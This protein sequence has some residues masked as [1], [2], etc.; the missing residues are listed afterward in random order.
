MRR[1]IN[2]FACEQKIMTQPISKPVS[3]VGS[4]A[5]VLSPSYLT[6]LKR[7][8]DLVL[9]GGETCEVWELEAPQDHACLSDW[10]RRFRQCYC[11]DELLE[12]LVEGTGKS[13]SQYLLE[14]VLPDK[15]QPP[16]PGIRS[17]DFAELLIADFV[18]FMLKYWV[19]REKYA[20]KGTR[21]ESVK[22]VDI[23]GFK[24]QQ[25]G[26]PHPDDEMLTFEVKAKLRADKYEGHL[27]DAVN[28]SAKD[29]LRAGQTLAA[30]KRRFL[31]RKDKNAASAVQRFQNLADNP[32]RLLSGAAAVLSDGACDDGGLSKT[33]VI[34][35]NN[36]KNLRLIVVKGKG[37]MDF[38]HA[39]YQR[40]AD[41]A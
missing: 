8:D 34:E 18:Q 16:G 15:S 32:Y 38:A 19:P 27:Q 11:P 40:A 5:K 9:E 37:L 24:F 1:G 36:S 13:K 20:E 4:S 10:A 7:V 39:L 6:Y 12:P 31:L 35:H 26:S 29:Y 17:G 25:P 28:D 30:M 3:V 22:G 23:I 2:R 14:F 33:S 41:E 21:N